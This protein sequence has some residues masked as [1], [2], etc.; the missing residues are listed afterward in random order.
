M[1]QQSVLYSD[2][3][4]EPPMVEK[5][6]GRVKTTTTQSRGAMIQTLTQALILP[7]IQ[8]PIQPPTQAPIQD[9]ALVWNLPPM[10]VPL[11]QPL[12]KTSP[13]L[14]EM[15]VSSKEFT[16]KYVTKFFGF[17]VKE[18]KLGKMCQLLEIWR[19]FYVS[20]IA[21][22]VFSGPLN[23]WGFHSVKVLD[24]EKW[25][26]RILEVAKTMARKFKGEPAIRPI[27]AIY[28]IMQYNGMT[29]QKSNG[30]RGPLGTRKNNDM[31]AL[32][33]DEYFFTVDAF[34]KKKKRARG[35]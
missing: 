21:K 3:A 16:E 9:Q 22:F 19:E 25:N 35:W 26:T 2:A 28:E 24:R 5:T 11:P 15:F 13:V 4:S 17:K 7:P 27:Q 8:P 23:V 1:I 34:E 20:N 12:P 33:Q 18:C 31:K 32:L 29:T 30:P 10:L 14:V 6:R